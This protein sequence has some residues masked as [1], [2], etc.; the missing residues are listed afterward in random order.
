MVNLFHGNGNMVNS[1]NLINRLTAILC[2][3]LSSPCHFDWSVANGR[4]LLCD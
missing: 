4:N 3:Y 2:D 1:V